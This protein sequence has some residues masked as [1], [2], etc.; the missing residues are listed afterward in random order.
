MSSNR[1]KAALFDDASFEVKKT[2]L[3]AQSKPN[4]QHT[5]DEQGAHN[6]HD[7]Q[8][9]Q[10]SQRKQ[11]H[12]RINMAFYGNNL[13]YLR[14]AAWKARMSVTEYVNALIH[15]DRERNL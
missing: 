15:Q 13:D 8:G 9:A 5:Q 14:N 4:T 11:K 6:T 7:T 1:G 2:E 12:P 10:N 3:Y